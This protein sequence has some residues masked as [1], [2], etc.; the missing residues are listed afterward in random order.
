[1]SLPKDL[2]RP[3]RPRALARPEKYSPASGI[4]RRQ[5][6]SM[7]GNFLLSFIYLLRFQ[8]A[9]LHHAGVLVDLGADKAR[10][11][12][13]RVDDHLRAIRGEAVGHFRRLQHGAVAI[14]VRLQ[15]R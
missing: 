13:R 3:A 5:R 7:I 12:L 2:I 1:M 14:V 8:P 6:T 9:L 10:K 4:V 11:L 15:D